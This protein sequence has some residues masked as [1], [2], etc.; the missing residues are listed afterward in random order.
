MIRISCR[1]AQPP[2]DIEPDV[3]LRPL[4]NRKFKR[5]AVTDA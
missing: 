3:K 5:Q 4:P 1:K 2:R